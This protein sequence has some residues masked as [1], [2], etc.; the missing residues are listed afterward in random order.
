MMPNDQLLTTMLSDTK[1]KAAHDCTT[2]GR[3]A[4]FGFTTRTGQQWFCREHRAEGE[5]VLITPMQDH[6]SRTT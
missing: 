1:P 2:C 5:K 4:P 3:G 6:R